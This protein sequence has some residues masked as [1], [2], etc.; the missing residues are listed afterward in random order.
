MRHQV[1]QFIDIEDKVFGP[2]TIKQF[3]YV[4]GGAA[5]AFIIWSL[6]P[7]YIAIFLVIPVL[8]LFGSLAFLKINNRP[9]IFVMESAVKYFLGSKLYIWKKKEKKPVLSNAPEKEELTLDI[10]KL[11]DSKLKELTW[12]L[13]INERVED[14]GNQNNNFEV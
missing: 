11:T 5:I 10:P 3:L 9:F 8:A 4:A 2:L 7:I 1:P 13:D 12:S 14:S 6:L